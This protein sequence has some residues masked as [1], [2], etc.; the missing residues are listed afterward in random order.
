MR[1]T[2]ECADAYVCD[3]AFSTLYAPPSDPGT[4]YVPIFKCQRCELPC[5]AWSIGQRLGQELNPQPIFIV[6]LKKS[7]LRDVGGTVASFLL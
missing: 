4:C 7:D 1:V 3:S 2:T 5:S 6:Q